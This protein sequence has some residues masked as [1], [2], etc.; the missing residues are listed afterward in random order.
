MFTSIVPL[1]QSNPRFDLTRIWFT[2]GDTPWNF[3][4]DLITYFHADR[5][6]ANMTLN[7]Y[8]QGAND[9]FHGNGAAEDE[10]KLKSI[11]ELVTNELSLHGAWTRV[12][13]HILNGN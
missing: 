11:A 9:A 1:F 5:E 3:L 8:P 2:H 10:A 7:R 12:N 4:K 13:G 6:R